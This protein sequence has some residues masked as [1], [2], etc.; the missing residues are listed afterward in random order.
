MRFLFY[1]TIVCSVLVGC[2][3]S[4]KAAANGNTE[5]LKTAEII[6]NYH[7]KNNSYTSLKAALTINLKTAEKE[8]KFTANL[9]ILKNEKIWLSI[10]KMGIPGAK[11]L[12]SPNAVKYYNKIDN[13]YFDGDYSIINAWLKTDIT[14]MQLQGILLGEAMYT[15]EPTQYDSEVLENGYLLRPEQ[16]TPQVEHYITLNPG[17]FK[18]KSQEIAQPKAYR[19]L[20]VDYKEY[21]EVDKQLIPMLVNL[22][23]VEKT[24][25]TQIDISYRNVSLNQDLRFPFKIPNNYKEISIEN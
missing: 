6:S 13:T 24:S 10:G 7:K 14:F 1:I 15:L 22:F 20:T 12:I 21:Q 4:K 11:I 9:R 2:K 16:L 25:E 19:I 8:E 18:V 17:N 5:K 3:A 23:M